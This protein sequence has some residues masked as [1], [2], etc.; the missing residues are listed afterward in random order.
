MTTT[1]MED[2]GGSVLIASAIGLGAD[3]VGQTTATVPAIYVAATGASA[4][5]F[6][7][8]KGSLCINT[9]GAGTTSRLWVNTTGST[10]WTFVGTSGA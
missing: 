3:T 8:A 10:V 4:P 6:L 5:T 7:A 1:L 2:R 9:T